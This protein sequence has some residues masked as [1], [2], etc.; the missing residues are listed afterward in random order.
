MHR[1][2]KSPAEFTAHAKERVS[3]KLHFRKGRPIGGTADAQAPPEHYADHARDAESRAQHTVVDERQPQLHVEK[4]SEFAKQEEE[5]A[6]AREP[7]KRVCEDAGADVRWVTLARGAGEEGLPFGLELGERSLELLRC[8]G[9]SL[10]A[11]DARA[12][13]CVGMRLVGVNGAPIRGRGDVDAALRSA[14]VALRFRRGA[15]AA[16]GD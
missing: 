3:V 2:V 12:R 14:A 4:L 7:S 5:A 10:A 16:P 15:G 1:V 13:G 9:G 11:R 8:A 6:A